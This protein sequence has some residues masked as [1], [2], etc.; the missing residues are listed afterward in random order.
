M[1][2]WDRRSGLLEDFGVVTVGSVNAISPE[3][4][5]IGG[6]ARYGIDWQAN[7][8]TQQGGLRGIG[9]LPGS[10]TSVVEGLSS[11][12][13]VAVGLGVYPGGLAQAWRWTE[14]GGFQGLGYLPGATQQYSAAWDI[15]ADGRRIVGQS[16]TTVGGEAFLW[17]EETGMVSLQDL[18]G[19]SNAGKASAI[20]PNGQWIAGEGRNERRREA[21][22]WT[23]DGDMMSLGAL[24]GNEINRYSYAV[25]VSDD[26]RVVI[27]ESN[28]VP[29]IWTP[30]WGMRP[31]REVLLEFGIN[32]AQ[33]GWGL[34]NITAVSADGTYFAANLARIGNSDIGEGALIYLPIPV[35]ASAVVMAVG[36][37]AFG[38]RRRR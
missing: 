16:N 12:G 28:G 5:A 9:R 21:V 4:D 22:L 27:G 30:E 33:D 11:N 29:M 15:S 7:L 18:A 37:G 20:S 3:G 2:R 34:I 35:P 25:D 36:F 31:F 26:G 13:G 32:L 23:A 14:K 19:G 17:T 10:T 8:W 38:A 1:V 24:P 6:Y